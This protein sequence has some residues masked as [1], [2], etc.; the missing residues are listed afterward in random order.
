METEQHPSNI[1]A[2]IRAAF[3]EASPRQTLY[4]VSQFATAEPA[5]STA[6]IRNLIFRA[7]PRHSS[8]GQIP[9][10]GLLESGA[11]VRR[12]RKVMIH[13]ERFLEWVQR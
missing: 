9:G 5:F 11:V 2:A 10:N 4:T 7:E 8:K 1:A 12:G 6:A 13:R 3:P